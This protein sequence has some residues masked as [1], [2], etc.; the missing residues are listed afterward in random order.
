MVIGVFLLYVNISQIT[1]LILLVHNLL[2][3]YFGYRKLRL[4]PKGFGTGT[5]TCLSLFLFFGDSEALPPNK[6]LFA[7]YK[8]RV[9]DQIHGNHHEETG[10][11]F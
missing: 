6:K 5:G 9:R 2:S 3:L 8:L 11:F 1:L 4:N 10:L 7:K